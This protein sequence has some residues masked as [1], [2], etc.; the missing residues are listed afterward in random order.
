MRVLWHIL[1][2]WALW[3]AVP[4]TWAGGEA[5]VAVNHNAVIEIEAGWFVMGSSA[6]DLKIAA[7]L[8]NLKDKSLAPCDPDLF[9]DEV[10]ARR[11][12]LST[13]RI[14][15]TEV[16]RRAYRRCVL[17][18]A[19]APS[20]IPDSD[21][22]LGQP[23]FPVTGL[24]WSEANAYCTWASGSLPTEAQWERA[25][26]GNGKRVFPW[27]RS[28][29]GRLAN[30]GAIRGGSDG[31]DG[32]VHAAPV[33]AFEQGKSA[34][35]LL[36]MAG[37]AWELTRDRY[38]SDQYRRAPSVNPIGPAQGEGRVIRGGSWF[39]PLY[40]LRASAR[41]KIGENE[42]RPDIGFRCVY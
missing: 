30:H 19:C 4:A 16:S 3:C 26:K 31:S 6:D 27:G 10:P 18:N 12:Y 13:Y 15:R 41:A 14:D 32:Y 34:N 24:T 36:N 1:S 23:D 20:R 38:L 2:V 17:A 25:A 22:K 28:Y 33:D 9:K 37:N 35:G 40:A 29:D 21:P 8:C 11:V 39:S 42:D 7:D 5:L